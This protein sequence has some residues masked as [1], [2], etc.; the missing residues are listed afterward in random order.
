MYRELARRVAVATIGFLV[1]FQFLGALLLSFFG[2][3]LPIVQVTRELV[4]VAPAWI[5]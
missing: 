2:L 3:S 4:I 1:V 5:R